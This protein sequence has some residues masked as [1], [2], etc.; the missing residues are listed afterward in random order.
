MSNDHL[1][2]ITLFV[3]LENKKKAR[4]NLAKI[5][6]GKDPN[7]YVIETVNVSSDPEKAAEYNIT[8]TPALV[9]HLNGIDRVFHNLDDHY[10]INYSLG[11]S[12]LW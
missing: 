2:K 1:P 7:S 10:A 12:K 11:L 4:K 6:A 9:C 8:K 3:N 5:L